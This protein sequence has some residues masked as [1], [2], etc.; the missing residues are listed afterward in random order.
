M[1]KLSMFLLCVCFVV[2]CM[3]QAEQSLSLEYLIGNWKYIEQTE[4]NQACWVRCFRDDKGRLAFKFVR[5]FYDAEP[6]FE[7]YSIEGDEVRVTFNMVPLGQRTA[8]EEKLMFVLKKTSKGDL[9]GQAF[10]HGKNGRI[11]PWTKRSR[12]MN[13]DPFTGIW[14]H[15]HESAGKKRTHVLRCY[16]DDK[17][18]PRFEFLRQYYSH[19]PVFTECSVS[20]DLIEV[21]FKLTSYERGYDSEYSIKY[22]LK[23]LNGILVGQLN[24]SWKEPVDVTLTHNKQL[25]N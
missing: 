21:K 15:P 5:Q 20:R 13:T 3:K 16:R 6:I 2:G 1:K 14:R 17:G 7:G 8:L 4:P 19:E 22:T 10:G 23:P 11:V 18:R 25:E 24:E 9:G 12:Y